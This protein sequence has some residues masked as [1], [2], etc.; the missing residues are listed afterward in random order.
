MLEIVVAD[1][2]VSD[3]IKRLFGIGIQ[4]FINITSSIKSGDTKAT[5]REERI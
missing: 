4:L 1:S 5:G 3:L 2:R